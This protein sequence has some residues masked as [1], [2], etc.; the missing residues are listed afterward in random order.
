MTS[1]VLI[2]CWRLDVHCVFSMH[3]LF[4]GKLLSLHETTSTQVIMIWELLFI[5]L[6]S[7][8]SSSVVMKVPIFSSYQAI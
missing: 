3:M 4:Q 2:D 5:L 8:G 7:V 6:A 1:K